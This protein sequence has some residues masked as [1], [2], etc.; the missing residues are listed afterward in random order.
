[1]GCKPINTPIEFNRGLCDA[2]DDSMVDKGSY[3]RLV[4]KLIYLAHTRPDIAFVVNVVSQFM[5]DP[6]EMHLKVVHRILEYLKGNPGRGI[7]P[8]FRSLH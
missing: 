3:Q 7:L 2:P 1:M 8:N 6:K 4:G 5:L